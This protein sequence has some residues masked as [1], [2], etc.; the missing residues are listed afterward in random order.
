MPATYREEFEDFYIP[1]GTSGF[2]ANLFRRWSEVVDVNGQEVK[3]LADLLAERRIDVDPT[4][5][6]GEAMTY[7][8]DPSVLER[9]EP[10]LALPGQAETWR[11][12]PHPYSKSWTDEQFAAAQK[13]LGH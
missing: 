1:P 2:D 11:S 4:L 7:G 6:L 8:N 10:D 12:G 13:K 5:A 3:R 9:L